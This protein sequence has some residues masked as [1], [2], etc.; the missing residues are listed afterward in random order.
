[1]TLTLAAPWVRSASSVPS[2]G[3]ASSRPVSAT[4]SASG[5]IQP[6]APSRSIARDT[7]S[8]P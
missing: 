3:N 4:T 5:A 8:R 7:R 2:S 6:I 1:M